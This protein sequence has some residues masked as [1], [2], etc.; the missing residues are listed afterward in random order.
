MMRPS[1]PAPSKSRRKNI[2]K[3]L[4]FD[5]LNRD[6]FKCRY[7]GASQKDGATLHIDH[8]KPVALGGRNEITNLVTACAECNLGKSAKTLTQKTPET[9]GVQ[10]PS[11]TFGLSFN[12]DGRAHWQFVIEQMSEHAAKITLFSWISGDPNG[13]EHVSRDFLSTRC[14]LF[15]DHAS[16]IA[17]ADYWGEI[18]WCDGWMDEKGRV[19]PKFVA[20]PAPA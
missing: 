9:A 15:A 19:N 10:K 6:G 3:G 5:V 14:Q 4:R 8:V 1:D 16:F 7:C 11:K 20:S 2:S 18:R 13:T 17:A 12:P